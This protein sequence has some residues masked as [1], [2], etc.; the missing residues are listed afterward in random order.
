MSD[1]SKAACQL[2]IQHLFRDAEYCHLWTYTFADDVS[3]Q[4]AARRWRL[5]VRWHVNT[6][7]KCVRV[8]ESG[9]L[10]GRWHYH[11]VTPER[12]KV[13]EVREA[14]ERYGFARIN[15]KRLPASRAHYVAKYLGKQNRGNLPS[16][17]R[18]WACVGFDGVA[19]NRVEASCQT[20]SLPEKMDGRPYTIVEWNF[21]GSQPIRIRIRL[22]ENPECEE[23]Q[24]LFVSQLEYDALFADLEA[25]EI[26]MLGVYRGLTVTLKSRENEETETRIEASFIEHVIECGTVTEYVS[27][28]L[29]SGSDINAVSLAA[30]V[31]SVVKVLVE[32]IRRYKGR[33]FVAGVVKPLIE[34]DAA[35]TESGKT[36]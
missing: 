8:L 32:S 19:V 23:V 26:V 36:S 4:E 5:F 6:G 21:P 9:S 13:D 27:E 28:R 3:P 25:G 2:S 34:V 15:V 14:A 29:P 31:G 24:R 35:K 30:S 10:N 33:R 1:L 18:R 20:R 17:Q 7:R 16:G 11:C 22:T 12:W